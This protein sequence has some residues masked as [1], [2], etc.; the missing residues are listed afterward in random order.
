VSEW[1]Y[2]VLDKAPTRDPV[3]RTEAAVAATFY[4]LFELRR[5]PQRR[6]PACLRS[7]LY[8]AINVGRVLLGGFVVFLYVRNG[9][10]MRV[11]EYF[12]L[13]TSAPLALK[14]LLSGT[15]PIEPGKTDRDLPAKNF[16]KV[17]TAKKG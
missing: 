3:S 8:W 5:V 15:P 13:G 6:R 7:K 17:L 16:R 10:V 2:A 1:F 9:D 12:Y 4:E 11:F 14:G